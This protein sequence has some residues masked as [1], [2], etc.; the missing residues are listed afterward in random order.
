M[1][2]FSF[3]AAAALVVSVAAAPNTGSSSQ[4]KPVSDP[5]VCG[6]TK[7]PD[8]AAEKVIAAKVA[9]LEARIASARG[10]GSATSRQAAI[11]AVVATKNVPVYFHVIQ[12]AAGTSTRNGYISAATINSQISVLNQGFANSG[13]SFTLAGSDYT[14]NKDWF[15]NAG[16]STSQQTAMK[17]ALRKGTAAT[18]NL[19]SV[20]FVAGSG[21]GL[22]GYATF[23]ESYRGAPEDDGVVFL[24]SSVPGGATEN[25]NKGKTV[26]HE[27][28]HWVGLYHTFQGGCTGS[29]DFVADTP[30]EASPASGCPTGRD[31]CSSAG[32]DPV[33]NYMDY[34]YD[35][36]MDNFTSGQ[37]TRLISQLETYR[38]L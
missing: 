22:L 8:A 14:V 20:G 38:G 29:G 27:V 33:T 28:G 31:T 25:Y 7:T 19:Y 6:T 30:A 9:A 21:Q 13:V 18:L 12:N 10:S 26:T 5:R 36:C 24:Y 32:L 2:S 16:P 3:L 34:S 15:T 37:S 1:R 17:N 23:P 11:A 35:S 4:L